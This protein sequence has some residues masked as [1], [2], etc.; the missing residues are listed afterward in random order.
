MPR[1]IPQPDLTS[2]DRLS[3]VAFIL[4][5]GVDRWR[6]QVK[7]DRIMPDS[8]PP[9][10][11]KTGLATCSETSLSVSHDTHGLSLRDDGDTA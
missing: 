3:K 6:R 1:N 5:K 8:E 11:P 10:S 7:P 9:D 2:E 4:A